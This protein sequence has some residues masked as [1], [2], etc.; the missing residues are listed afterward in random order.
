MSSVP[1]TS[2]TLL[3]DIGSDADSPR[4]AEFV[5][6]YRPMM[7]DYLASRWPGL[8]AEADDL[9]QE[10]LL[11]LV[12]ALPGYR[13]VPGEQGSFHNYLTGILRNKALMALRRRD[14]ESA[15]DARSA[16][17]PAPPQPPP[18]D[19]EAAARE[20]AA[21]RD[22]V[23]EIALRQLLADDSVQERTKQAFVRVAVRGEDPAA[24]ARDFGI[25]RNAVDQM[26]SRLTRRLRSLVAALLS[27]RSA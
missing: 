11:A 12:R 4:W 7:A 2:A 18:A 21:W 17:E 23:F 15:R 8:S 14:A 9:V 16:A 6:R 22:A 26:K 3:R 5:A 25:E 27:E 20:E 24:V 10:T 1:S 19:E 13:Y